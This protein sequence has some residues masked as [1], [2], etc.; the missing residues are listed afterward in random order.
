MPH[1]CLQ[2]CSNCNIYY[3]SE[4]HASLL[5]NF[6]SFNIYHKSLRY[7]ITLTKSNSTYSIDIVVFAT[8]LFV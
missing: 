1:L 2:I 4:A 6:S 5:E 7:A 3:R 8:I